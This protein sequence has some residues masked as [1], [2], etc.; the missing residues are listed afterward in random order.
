MI[1]FDSAYLAKCHP[2]EPGDREVRILAQN[3]GRLKSGAFAKIEVAAVFH[4]HLREG[5][6]R[7]A[8]HKEFAIQFIQDSTDGLISFLPIT[9]ALLDAARAVFQ[10]LPPRAL[11]SLGGLPPPLQ[12]KGSRLQRDLF[13][14]SAPFGSRRAFRSSRHRCDRLTARLNFV[15]DV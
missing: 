2:P 6:L 12:C 3:A 7:P 15:R 11:S 5:R 14:R 13:Q 10:T 9:P 8:E 1:Y 4:R